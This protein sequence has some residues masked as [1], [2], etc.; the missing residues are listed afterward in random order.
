MK[1][2]DKGKNSQN[3]KVDETPKKS[4][5]AEKGEV[6]TWV[7]HAR[8]FELYCIWKA[9]PVMLK[10]ESVKNLQEK[11]LIDD[12]DILELCQIRTQTAFANHFG[13]HIDTLTGWNKKIKDREP[14]GD[15]RKWVNTVMKNVMMSTYR[16][17]MSKDPKA[18]AD[19]KLML[20][21]TGW[22][23]E[24]TLN[25]KGEGLFDILKREMNESREKKNKENESGN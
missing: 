24:Q 18:H 9:L 3:S 10:S 13:L 11:Y 16:S 17:A 25:I 23:E 15:I 19:R 5:K 14:F 21:F 8:E 7:V 20:N 2:E 1:A 22:N 6:S 12:E 4:E